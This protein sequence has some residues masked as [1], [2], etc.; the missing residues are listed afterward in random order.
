M[1]V[2]SIN[3]L[4]LAISMAWLLITSLAFAGTNGQHSQKEKTNQADIYI[5]GMGPGD[6]DL[7]TVSAE[8]TVRKADLIICNPSC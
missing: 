3:L 1:K 2:R 6:V 5:V 8:Q 7:I 4:P